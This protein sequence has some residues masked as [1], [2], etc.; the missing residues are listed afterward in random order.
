[1]LK[2]DFN[3]NIISINK[4]NTFQSVFHSFQKVLFNEEYHS[5]Y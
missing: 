5:Q 4:E 3:R 1:M 2:D